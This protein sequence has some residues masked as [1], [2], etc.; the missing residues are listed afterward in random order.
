MSKKGSSPV[1]DGLNVTYDVGVET[2]T[3]NKCSITRMKKGA[4]AS[5]AGCNFHARSRADQ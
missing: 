5:S 3:A 4:L 1:W 2:C